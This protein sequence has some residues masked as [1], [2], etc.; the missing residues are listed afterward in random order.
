MG[1]PSVHQEDTLMAIC[2]S[3]LA[4]NCQELRNQISMDGGQKLDVPGQLAEFGPALEFHTGV[5]A[6]GPGESKPNF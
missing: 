6:S 3:K 4:V 5:A 2:G 1:A